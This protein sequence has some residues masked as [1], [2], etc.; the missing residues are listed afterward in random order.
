V[1]ETS[2]EETGMPYANS[3]IRAQTVNLAAPESEPSDR[4]FISSLR[5]KEVSAQRYS[6]LVRG[7]WN[8]ENGSHWQRD[9]LWREDAHQMRSHRRAHVLS[10][11]RQVAL[12][13]HS[14]SNLKSTTPCAMSHRARQASIQINPTIGLITRPIRE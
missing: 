3:L 5:P 12:H 2:A 8:I 13:L 14:M 7:H 1:H 4:Y 10:T 6:E 11:L 9:T